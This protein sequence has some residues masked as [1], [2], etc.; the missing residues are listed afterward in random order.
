[1]KTIR[2]KRYAAGSGQFVICND[3][4]QLLEIQGITKFEYVDNDIDLLLI[5]FS[6]FYSVNR[7]LINSKEFQ[8]DFNNAKHVVVCCLFGATEVGTDIKQ[9]HEHIS[10]FSNR[11]FVILHNI[12]NLK[13][14]NNVSNVDIIFNDHLFNV[15]KSYFTCFPYKTTYRLGLGKHTQEW[16][17]GQIKNNKSRI[18]LAPNKYGAHSSRDQLFRFLTDRQD[19]LESKGFW[20]NWSKHNLPT[21]DQIKQEKNKFLGLFNDPILNPDNNL[22]W[23]NPLTE[24]IQGD[25]ISKQTLETENISNNPIHFF[26]YENTFLSIFVESTEYDDVWISEKTFSPLANGHFILPY[27]PPKIVDSVKKI[28]FKFPEFINYEYDNIEDHNHRMLE[29]IKEIDRLTQIDLNSWYKLFEENK[30]LLYYNKQLFH[31]KPFQY[32]DYFQKLM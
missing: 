22:M 17:T 14:E 5:D 3:F 4:E 32:V 24:H 30:D 10:L 23:F 19:I 31:H 6:V 26:Y 8:T 18:F 28:G 13:I 9:L 29:W 7:H 20:S 25:I 16:K 2:I 11:H 12:H 1:M 15:F 21:F 27:G